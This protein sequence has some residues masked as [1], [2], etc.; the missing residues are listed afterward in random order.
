MSSLSYCCCTDELRFLTASRRFAKVRISDNVL[1]CKQDLTLFVGQIYRCIRLLML[2]CIINTALHYQQWPTTSA[3]HIIVRDAFYHQSCII[4]ST[5]YHFK[6]A[7]LLNTC[8]ASVT[9]H[10]IIN[11][12]LHHQHCITSSTLLCTWEAVL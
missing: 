2:Y 1:G 12:A 10:Y 3:T 5:I 6:K 11:T 9:L 7:A 8:L 4:L